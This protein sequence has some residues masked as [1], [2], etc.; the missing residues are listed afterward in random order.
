[1]RDEQHPTYLSEFGYTRWRAHCNV[2]GTYVD[3]WPIEPPADFLCYRCEEEGVEEVAATP[4][5]DDRD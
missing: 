1:M 5:E 2:C 4:K 3:D